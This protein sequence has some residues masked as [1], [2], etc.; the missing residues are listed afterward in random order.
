MAHAE[1]P[2]VPAASAT[3]LGGLHPQECASE[4]HLLSQQC[5]LLRC[6]LRALGQEAA[7]P[8]FGGAP[9]AFGVVPP[10]LSRG[11]KLLGEVSAWPRL[12]QVLEAF[13]PPV[14]DVSHAA[15][16]RPAGSNAVSRCTISVVSTALRQVSRTAV[17]ECA[18]SVGDF[19]SRHRAGHCR[20]RRHE[21]AGLVQWRQSERSTGVIAACS[22][23]ICHRSKTDS[24]PPIEAECLGVLS[25]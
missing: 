23:R 6:R 21:L 7:P 9:G 15:F 3:S 13:D 25:V 24:C 5:T 20:Q 16:S 11:T 22:F 12:R 1:A 10:V 19:A 4:M 18:S 8:L 2:G 14:E 17:A